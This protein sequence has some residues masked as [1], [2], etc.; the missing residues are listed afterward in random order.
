MFY[1]STL[2]KI[3]LLISKN[4]RKIITEQKHRYVTKEIRY[5]ETLSAMT[6][7]RIF[8][9]NLCFCRKRKP[10]NVPKQAYPT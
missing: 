8:C 9:Y 1:I 5:G 6:F 10:G 7:G 4:P 2:T 3:S